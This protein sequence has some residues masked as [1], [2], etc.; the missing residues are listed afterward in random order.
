[1]DH[2]KH[3]ESFSVFYRIHI[4]VSID[5]VLLLSTK[6]GIIL[7]FRTIIT[8]ASTSS[9]ARIVSVTE[10]AEVPE[11]RK[12]INYHYQNPI[13]RNAFRPPSHIVVP[14]NEYAEKLKA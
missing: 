7:Y 6:K 12:I 5:N 8:V 10:P 13:L 9:A 3:K 4:N 14:I 11:E 1:M 2:K